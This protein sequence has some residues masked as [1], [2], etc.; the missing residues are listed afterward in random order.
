[1]IVDGETG[2]LAQNGSPSSIG[3][4]VERLLAQTADERAQ[5]Q[6]NLDAWLEEVRKEDRVQQLLDFYQDAIVRPR[7]G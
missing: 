3:A 6:R 1:M 2:F 5:M 7:R 4:A